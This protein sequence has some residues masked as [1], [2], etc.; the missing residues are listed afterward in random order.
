MTI[1]A[2]LVKELRERTG[3]GMMECK[4]ALTET[5]GDIDA[6]IEL[7][8]KSGQAKADKK[9][10]RVAAEGL[11]QIAT[12]TDH[13]DAIIVEVNCETDFVARDTNFVDFVKR[14]TDL[15]LQHKATNIDTLANVIYD[16]KNNETVDQAR[17]NLIAKIGENISIRRLHHLHSE[18]Y[19]G[20]YLHG[21]RIGV[22]VALDKVNAELA[23]DIAMHVAANNPIVVS[24]QEVPA[25]VIAKEREIYTAQAE[26]SGKPADIIAKMVDGRIKKYLDEVS[27]LG[28]PF[29]KNPDITVAK[30]LQENGASVTAF[31][32]FAVGEGIEKEV[33]NFAEEVMAQIRS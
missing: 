7:M 11:I 10:S 15:A 20:S 27:L 25:D 18:H 26:G 5:N 17:K 6:A 23:K 2:T 8:R 31:V 32:R 28:Q 33:T 29:V 21:T 14:V 9:A 1:S 22:L 4:K 30:L 13:K 19:V 12:S 3:S 16:T 24:P